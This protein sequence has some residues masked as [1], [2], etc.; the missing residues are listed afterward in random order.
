[1]G[2]FGNNPYN[3]DMPVGTDGKMDPDAKLNYWGDWR[4]ALLKSRLR[5][6]Y[7]IDFSGKNKKADYFISAGYLNDKGVFSIQR[8]SKDIPLSTES[9]AIYIL[10]E[11]RNQ[12]QFVS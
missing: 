6:E 4:N 8:K 10:V 12:H 3:I 5:Q 11:G 2:E 9:Q 7:T 1:M